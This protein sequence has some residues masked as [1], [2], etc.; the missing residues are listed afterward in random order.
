MISIQ[1]F[2]VNASKSLE[3]WCHKQNN[4]ISS[5]STC[6]NL[7][8]K[9]VLVEFYAEVSNLVS[10]EQILV[11]LPI[12]II[13]TTY[14]IMWYILIISFFHLKNVVIQG[15]NTWWDFSQC[16]SRFYCWRK[17]ND[18]ENT[19]WYWLLLLYLAHTDFIA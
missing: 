19:W 1:D 17:I 9:Q 8:K 11:W 2:L 18:L 6:L 14:S 13:S 4:I 10:F 16:F 3:I 12:H 7:E 5:N 15:N